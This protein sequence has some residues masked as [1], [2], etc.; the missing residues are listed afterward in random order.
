MRKTLFLIWSALAIAIVSL[1][2]GCGEDEKTDDDY[3]FYADIGELEQVVKELHD[4]P[5]YV[6]WYQRQYVFIC[7]SKYAEEFYTSPEPNRLPRYIYEDVDTL[8]IGVSVQDFEKYNI[9]MNT[10]VYVSA[11]VTDN[12]SILPIPGEFDPGFI[13]TKAAK[14]YLKNLRPMD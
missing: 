10:W 1:L 6:Y 11:T 4:E 9:P 12:C 14:A 2:A 7:Y 3:P 8:R 5:A 13:R